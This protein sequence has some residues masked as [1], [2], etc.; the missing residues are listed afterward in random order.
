MIETVIGYVVVVLFGLC[1]GSFLN[2]LIYRIPKHEDFVKSRSHCMSCGHELA[3]Y[4]MFPVFSYI[5]L[6]G[7]CRYCGA[8]LSI[9]YPLIEAANG[10]LWGLC[11]YRYGF[12]MM[13]IVTAGLLSALVVIAVIDER[14]MEIPFGLNVFIFVLAVIKVASEI[15]SVVMKNSTVYAFVYQTSGDEVDPI[16]KF[17]RFVGDN[18]TGH[19]RSLVDALIGGEGITVLHIVVTHLIGFVIVSGVMLLLIIISRG[20]WIGGGDAK[21]MAAAGLFLG[22]KLIILSLFLGCIVGTVVHLIRMKVSGADRQLAMGPYL[23]LG[24]GVNALFGV[25]LIFAYVS[26]LG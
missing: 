25:D 17:I 14:T 9:Q 6:R 15:I 8:K 20:H 4:D 22:W 23:A 21:L 19:F 7:K 26:A 5:F 1:V 12:S 24:I 11:F 10:A 18:D 3:W 2:V 13:G 16:L